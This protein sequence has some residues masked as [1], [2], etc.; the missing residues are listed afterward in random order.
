MESMVFYAPLLGVVGLFI[1]W[2]IFT[3]VRKQPM[4]N[5]CM[6]EIAGLVRVGATA[7][8]KREYTALSI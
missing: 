4:G 5:P 2:M 7:F 3:Y 8:L 6:R 1:A